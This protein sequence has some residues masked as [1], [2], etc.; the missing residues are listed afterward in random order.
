VLTFSCHCLLLRFS[1]AASSTNE[2]ELKHSGSKGF[3][4]MPFL[5]IPVPMLRLRPASQCLQDH[6]RMWINDDTQLMICSRSK[7][8]HSTPDRG[9]N[10]DFLRVNLDY[11]FHNYCTGTPNEVVPRVSVLLAFCYLQP[12][13]SCPITTS[14]PLFIIS[15]A[16]ALSRS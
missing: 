6:V 14:F 8:Y 12:C 1:C 3:G 7:I 10:P 4:N 13:A 2:T 11:P 16:S 9:S 15:S 5:R